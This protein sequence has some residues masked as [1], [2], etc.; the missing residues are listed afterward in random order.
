MEDGDILG[1]FESYVVLRGVKKKNAGHYRRWV[2]ACFNFA[3]KKPGEEIA[4]PEKASF[5]AGETRKRQDWQVKQAAMALELYDLFLGEQT[6]VK[7]PET[8]DPTGF[9]EEWEAAERMLNLFLGRRRYRSQTRRAYHKWLIEFR[10]F[11][12]SRPPATLE[13]WDVESFMRY[14][15]SRP[16]IVSSQRKQAVTAIRFFFRHALNKNIGDSLEAELA[17]CRGSFPVVLDT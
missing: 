11:V 7:D 1:R 17:K 9:K 4:A 8:L 13:I 5:L 3:E 16:S 10:A 14:L 6:G 15:A 2:A 12:R